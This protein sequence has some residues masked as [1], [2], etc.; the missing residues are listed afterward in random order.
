MPFARQPVEFTDPQ[1]RYDLYAQI[2]ALLWQ[3]LPMIPI[4]QAIG[5]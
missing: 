1:A 2:D 4:Y 5:A 3:D